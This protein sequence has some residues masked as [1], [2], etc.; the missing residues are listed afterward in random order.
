MHS[1]TALVLLDTQVNMFEESTA[2]YNAAQLLERLQELLRQARQ[3]GAYII[4]IQNNGAEGDPDEPGTP[5]WAFHPNL[6]PQEGE[7]VL[8]KSTPDAFADTNLDY[9]LRSRNIIRLVL[10]GLQSD[11]CIHATLRRA[12]DLGYEVVLIQ[13][14][15][16]TFDTEDMSAAELIEL[17]NAEL[18]PF[19]NVL[20]ISEVDFRIL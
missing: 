6:A 4:H 11:L 14:G 15:H 13:D 19:A 10:A 18:R 9:E 5:G 12:V 1:R 20:S 2:A 17:V 16:S 7:T 3:T 8:Q